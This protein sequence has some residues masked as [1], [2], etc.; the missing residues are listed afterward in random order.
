[1][2]RNQCSPIFWARISEVYFDQAIVWSI[3]ICTENKQRAFICYILCIDNKQ[4]ISSYNTLCI[5]HLMQLP[6]EPGEFNARLE[7]FGNEKPSIL[8]SASMSLVKRFPTFQRIVAI[9]LGLLDPEDADTTTFVHT[10]NY[11]T[12]NT[13]KHPRKFQSSGKSLWEH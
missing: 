1:M 6:H 12:N 2:L 9:H 13:K 3:F 4:Y 5:T 8:R 11:A 10:G 7:V